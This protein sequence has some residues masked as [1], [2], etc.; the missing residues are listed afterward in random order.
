MLC[1]GDNYGFSVPV[2]FRSKA[3]CEDNGCSLVEYWNVAA[4][5]H[6][7][8]LRVSLST[9][10]D[11]VAPLDKGAAIAC[12]ERLAVNV[13]KLTELAIITLTEH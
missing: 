6:R 12:E 5:R 3:Q 11:C 13:D 1:Q 8:A 2:S 10:T 7:D 9:P 4:G